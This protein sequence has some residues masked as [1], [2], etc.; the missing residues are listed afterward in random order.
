MPHCLQDSE[1]KVKITHHVENCKLCGKCPIKELIEI[2]G[3]YGVDLAVAT[4]GTIARRIVLER[5]PDLIIAVACER[6]L[7]S[8]IQD[9]TPFPFT[10]FSTNVLSGP[11][12]IP[13]VSLERVDA[14][15]QEIAAM[16]REGP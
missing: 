5:R 8:G 16:K 15:L 14:V 10:G 6:D 7:T 13:G 1:C 3:R 2:S 12:S 9:T 4:G 11:A